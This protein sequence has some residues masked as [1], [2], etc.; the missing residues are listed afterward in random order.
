MLDS[1][2]LI[3]N[4]M[5]RTNI[6]KQQHQWWI[7]SFL[8]GNVFNINSGE[9]FGKMSGVGAGVDSFYEYLLKVSAFFDIISL[10]D[11]LLCGR[12]YLC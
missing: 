8:T 9:W 2:V 11:N 10:C 5:G 4:P 7:R 1:A 6:M 3:L 12:M